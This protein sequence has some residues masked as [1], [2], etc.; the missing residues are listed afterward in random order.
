LPE[1]FLIL[2]VTSSRYCAAL[3]FIQINPDRRLKL[4]INRVA[5]KPGWEEIMFSPLAVSVSQDRMTG[6]ETLREMEGSNSR[7]SPKPVFSDTL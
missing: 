1:H 2:F 4:F 5:A 7:Y 3:S 6:E